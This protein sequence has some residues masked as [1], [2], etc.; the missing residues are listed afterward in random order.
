[1][2]SVEAVP[3]AYARPATL[4][5]T[6]GRGVPQFPRSSWRVVQGAPSG[7]SGLWGTVRARAVLG[8]AVAASAQARAVC[9]PATGLDHSWRSGRGRRR[10]LRPGCQS[11]HR[12]L[13]RYTGER[14]AEKRSVPQRWIAATG[15]AP[16]RQTSPERRGWPSAVM[17]RRGWSCCG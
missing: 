10:L 7:G 9:T 3:A 8:S 14:N 11:R 16:V 17:S 5:C 12:A 6:A 2:R 13:R 15:R 4:A 1:M